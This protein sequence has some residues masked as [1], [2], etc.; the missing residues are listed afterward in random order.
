MRKVTPVLAALVLALTACTSGA[1][2]TPEST[3]TPT[4]APPLTDAAQLA[5][6]AQ[7]AIAKAKSAKFT[8]DFG[9]NGQAVQASGL[10]A[11]EDGI[12]KYSVHWSQGD[13]L[14]I[15]K[16]AYTKIPPEQAALIAPGKSW[17]SADPNSPDPMTRALSGPAPTQQVNDPTHALARIAKA[18]RIL[19]SDQPLLHGVKV[20]HYRLEIDVAKAPEL[21]PEAERPPIDGKVDEKPKKAKLPAELWLDAD[22]LPARIKVGLSGLHDGQA[23][24]AFTADYTAW[25]TKVELS[26]PPADQVMDAT[27]LVKKMGR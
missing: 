19:S 3:P 6:A 25:G 7:Q 24:A 15:G 12:A 21:S 27:E 20:N 11:F 26:A 10:F 23:N 1:V 8:S 2:S 5:A 9:A 14:V 17:S 13:S 16:V 4:L 18:G 22:Q